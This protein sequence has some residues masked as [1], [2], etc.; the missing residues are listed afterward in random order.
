VELDI[1]YT[2]RLRKY[3]RI[4]MKWPNILFSIITFEAIIS[5]DMKLIAGGLYSLVCEESA[6]SRLAWR[7]VYSTSRYLKH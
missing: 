1:A 5:Y 7:I 2:P 4:R 6:T 3:V